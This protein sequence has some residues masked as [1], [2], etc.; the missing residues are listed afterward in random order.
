MAQIAGFPQ[1]Q[2]GRREFCGAGPGPPI[3]EASAFRSATTAVPRTCTATSMACVASGKQ[4]HPDTFPFSIAILRASIYPRA[5]LC[6]S[7]G[8]VFRNRIVEGLPTTRL[9]LRKSGQ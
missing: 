4:A 1:P 5:G 2:N 8:E 9:L 6:P 7:D 3:V